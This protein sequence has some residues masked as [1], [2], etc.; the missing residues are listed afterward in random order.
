MEETTVK[1]ATEPFFTTKGP[2]EGPVSG[3]RWSMAS[4]LK[5]GGA[6]RITSRS[7]RAP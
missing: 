7:A 1:R 2:G 3:C 4:S 6:M 5:S